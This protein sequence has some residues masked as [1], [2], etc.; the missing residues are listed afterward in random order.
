[1]SSWKPENYMARFFLILCLCC[2]FSVARAD[3]ITGGEMFY[4]YLGKV[5]GNNQYRVTLK[6]FM[7]CNSG[8]Q[9]NDPTIVSVFDRL[10]NERIQN[11]SV[12]LT[13]QDFLSLN[14]TNPCITNPP[15]V[16]YNMGMYEFTVILPDNVNGYLLA[17]QVNFRI[18]GISNLENGYSQIGATYTCEIPG[19]SN[20]AGVTANNSARFTGSDLV[21]VCANNSFSH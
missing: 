10:T 16:C 12:P 14:N 1:M 8:R 2:L 7:R 13:A 4:T 5:N 18:A 11:I 15:L 21:I 6:L 20:G 17:S 19:T 9:F 3:H